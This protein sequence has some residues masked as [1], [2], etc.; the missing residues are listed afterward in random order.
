MKRA[1]SDDGLVTCIACG[2]RVPRSDAREYDRYGDR[3]D[4]TGKEFEYL[5]KPCFTRE[6]HFP[7]RDLESILLTLDGDESSTVDFVRAYYRAV[8]EHEE[9]PDP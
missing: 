6:C 2:D 9:N 7:R 8:A 3:W 1:W 5:C 4:R